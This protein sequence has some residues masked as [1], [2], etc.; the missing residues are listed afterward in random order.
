[1]IGISKMGT[2]QRTGWTINLVVIGTANVKGF[3]VG[4]VAKI[5]AVHLN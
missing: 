2:D 3:P 5:R 4:V 1:M